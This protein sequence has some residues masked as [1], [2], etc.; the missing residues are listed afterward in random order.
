MI[1]FP[2]LVSVAKSTALPGDP[3]LKVEMDGIESP[4]WNKRRAEVLKLRAD[5]LESIVGGQLTVVLRW[6][7]MC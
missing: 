4:Y 1:D 5:N 7:G 2:S 3:S 6:K